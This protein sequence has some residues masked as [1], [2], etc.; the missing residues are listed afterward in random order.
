[1][2]EDGICEVEPELYSKTFKITDINYQIARREDQMDIFSKYC[3]VLNYCD[4]SLFI[5]I[6]IINKR[7][8]EDSFKNSMFLKTKNDELDTYRKEMNNMLTE[9]A[10]EGQNSV[11]RDKYITFSTR[12]NNYSNAVQTLSRL[13]TDLLSNF[14]SLGCDTKVLS[15]KERLELIHNTLRP[16]DKY[17]FEY[18]YLL[19]SSL[20][21]KDFVCPDSFNFTP[22]SNFEFGDNIGQVLFLK[23]LPPDLSDKL[24]SELSD[25]PI[26]MQI[27]LHINS[28]EQDKALNLVKQKISFME[29]QKIDEQKKALKSGY[30]TEMIP[31]E[32]KYSLNEAEELL[33]DLQNKNQRMFRVTLL[34]YTFADNLE[35]LNEKIY[36][37]MAAARKNNCKLAQLDYLQE[38]ALNSILP[39][40]KNHIDIK[41]TLT[42]AST[43]IFVP[44]T[45]QELFQQ[46]GMYYGLNALSRNL[47][48]FNRKLLKNSNGFILG[49]PGSGKSFAAKREI[50]NVLLSTDDEILVIDPEREYAPL[51]E[52]FGGEIIHISAGSQAHINPLDIT[53]D[54]SDSDDPLL[55]KSEFVLSLCELLIGGRNGLTSSQKTVLDRSCKLT[56]QKYF[57]NPKKYPVPTLK[58]FYKVLKEQP[59]SEAQSIALSLEIYIEGSLSVFAEPTNVDI[60]KRFVVFDIRD[61]GKQ[62]KTMG[63]LI[64]LDQIWNRITQNRAIGKRTW[65]YIDEIY[66]LFQNEYSANYLFEL[67]K[68]ARK[69]GAIPT[70]ITQNVEDLLISDLARRMLSNSEFIMML[71]QAAPDRLEL[72]NLLNISSQQLSYVTNSDEGEGLLFAGNSIIPFIDKFPTETKLYKMMTTKIEEVV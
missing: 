69:W 37:I 55:L 31:Y 56:Y 53:M 13:E 42:T 14:K 41:R 35:L 25:I 7:I 36:K 24:I 54:Y 23:D 44:F 67:Y 32:L 3:E 71:N 57:A 18:D 68:R 4:P 38:E 39:L 47:I 15:G 46:S 48:F 60:N 70:G 12:A 2:F 5:Q 66:L 72:A 45:T 27:T 28:V 29:Q 22:K 34:I 10:L 6:S 65:I 26:D 11:L 51:A 61:L 30:D 62:L 63:M 33:D 21:T 49:T 9:R 20:T 40:G 16:H 59:E 43:A 1:M 50:I 17:N 19:E 8:D 64:V 52:G 58:D